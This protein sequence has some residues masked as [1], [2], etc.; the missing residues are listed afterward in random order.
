ML[1]VQMKHRQFNTT[2]PS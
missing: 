2:S 1:D